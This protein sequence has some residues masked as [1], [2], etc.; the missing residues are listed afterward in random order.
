MRFTVNYRKLVWI[1]LLFNN[2]LCKF[3]IVH[4]N[5]RFKKLLEAAWI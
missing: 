5:F 1:N 3:A 4:G 2:N